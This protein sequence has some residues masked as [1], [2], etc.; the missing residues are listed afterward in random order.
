[1]I[2]AATPIEESLKV[3]ALQFEKSPMRQVLLE[4][5]ARVL[6]GAR[7]SEAMAAPI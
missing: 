3:V 7:L 5:R 6:E 4:T 1:L 2:D